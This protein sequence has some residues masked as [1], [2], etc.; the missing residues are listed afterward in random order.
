M[1]ALAIDGFRGLG[2]EMEASAGGEQ[3]IRCSA[4]AR[5]A[6]PTCA[7]PSRT[8]GHFRIMFSS[9]L[10]QGVEDPALADAGAP[11]L[12]ALVD[13]I[14]DGQR[15]RAGA[16]RRSAR[17]GAAGVVDGARAVDAADRAPG[18]TRSL[19]VV[20][21]ETLA[22]AVIDVTVRG[23]APSPAAYFFALRRLLRRL[24]VGFF[25]RPSPASSRAALFA[26]FFAFVR[27]LRGRR[28]FCLVVV[29]RAAS[30][31]HL[32][33]RLRP[34][35][36]RTMPAEAEAAP[37]RGH[38]RH[39]RRRI[40]RALRRQVQ[41]ARL[42]AARPEAALADDVVLALERLH[43][44]AEVGV[45]AHGVVDDERVAPAVR[46]QPLADARPEAPR[47]FHSQL[48]SSARSAGTTSP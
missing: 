30:L 16:R 23:L 40:Q 29:L 27:L 1:L 7:T 31:L 24:V 42:L 35:P 37:E 20:Y 26:S 32:R 6:W 10:H 22:H 36:D 3:T 28:R 21:A 13:T 2:A 9:E 43:Q 17:A 33:A 19:D 4:S 47:R 15:T 25:A 45:G 8:P 46:V 41:A 12:Q 11:T 48:P 18:A 5:S 14:A 39:H 44:R 38:R 34:A